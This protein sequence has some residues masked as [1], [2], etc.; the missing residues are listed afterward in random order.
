MAAHKDHDEIWLEPICPECDEPADGQ[1]QHWCQ[2]DVFSG[3][4]ENCG[5]EV[6][7]IKYVLAPAKP[8]PEDGG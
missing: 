8:E 6:T 3:A 2:D 1:Q 7:A 5:A 4:C